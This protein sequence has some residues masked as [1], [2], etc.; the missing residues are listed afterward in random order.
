[1][2]EKTII[3]ADYREQESACFQFLEKNPFIDLH[4]KA[5]SVGDYE[6]GD[7]I[8]ER[9]TL[10]DLAKSIIDGRLFN[11]MSR[12]LS[13]KKQAVYLIEGRPE[14]MGARGV[15]RAAL[16]G[17]LINITLTHNIP[18]LYA[19]TP[20]ESSSLILYTTQQQNMIRQGECHRFGYAPKNKMKRQL[21]IL[22]GLPDIGKK[23]S[24]LLLAHF[25]SVKKVMNATTAELTQIKGIGKISAKKIY[26]IINYHSANSK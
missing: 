12:L 9:K 21:Y 17:A 4:I 1:M 14:K 19:L 20:E 13:N 10:A 26:D 7:F 16:Q 11:Q 25:G 3:I 8:F 24:K 2:P 22:Q 18:V 5:L 23:R 6:I 15:S